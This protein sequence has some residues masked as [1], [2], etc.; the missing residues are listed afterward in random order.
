MKKIFVNNLGDLV[1]IQRASFY[2]FL[3][4]GIEEEL[5]NFPNPFFAKAPVPFFYPKSTLTRKVKAA[6]KKLAKSILIAEK[7]QTVSKKKQKV[8]DVK[9]CRQRLDRENTCL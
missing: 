2:R 9:K 6:K 1:E 4:S 3:S 5:T 8:N 7:I